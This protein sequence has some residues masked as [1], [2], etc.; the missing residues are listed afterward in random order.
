MNADPRV[1][2]HFPA[3]YT[4]ERSD[5]F[6]DRIEACWQEHG[7]GLWA[8][9]RPD[10]GVF[11]GFV[12]LSPATFQA[13]FT[14]TVEVGWRLAGEHWG[15]GFATEGAQAALSFGFGVG[16]LNEIVSFTAR[17]N[18]RSWRVMERLGMVRDPALDFDHPAVPAAHPV[19]PHVF[20]RMTRAQWTEL[21][22]LA[23]TPDSAGS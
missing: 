9:E 15:H 11:I 12:G 4:R 8:V 10:L 1:M 13:A 16:G 21:H 14:P 20:Y 7:Y 5:A 3:P 22:G 6:V 18:R 17:H 19:R 2:E 23:R